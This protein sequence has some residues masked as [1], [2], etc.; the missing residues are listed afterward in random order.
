MHLY[1]G[2]LIVNFQLVY[3]KITFK[4]SNRASD[5]NVEQKLHYE[6]YT[7]KEGILE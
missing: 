7:F 2:T 3:F 1:C 4:G 6:Q 5:H